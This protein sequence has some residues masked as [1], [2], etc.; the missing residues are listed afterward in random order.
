VF[1]DIG[2]AITGDSD[3]KQVFSNLYV[4]VFGVKEDDI[5]KETKP[6]TAVL[7]MG[8]EAE[9]KFLDSGGDISTVL[10]HFFKIKPESKQNVSAAQNISTT[11]STLEVASTTADAT[12]QNTGSSANLDTLSLNPDLP[13]NVTLDCPVLSISYMTPLKGA[14]SSAF[15]SRLHPV[16]NEVKFHYGVDIAAA[17][18]TDIKSFADG[19]VSAVGI[20]D[21]LGKYLMI[22]HSDNITTVYGHC[23]SVSVKTGEKVKKGEV[24]AA[25]GQT[26]DATGPHLHFE[27]HYGSMY[28]DPLNYISPE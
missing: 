28:I 11:E 19:K 26:G 10:E 22:Q 21:T 24:I 20:S 15:G 3:I 16:E 14:V 7:T 9:Q 2:K 5:S 27:M 4:S 17:S 6:G 8:L 12:S 1:S 18:G 25:V 13:A 23:S